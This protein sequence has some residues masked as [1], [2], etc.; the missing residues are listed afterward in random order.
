MSPVDMEC[1]MEKEDFWSKMDEVVEK[2]PKEERVV[3]GANFNGHVGEGNRVDSYS[4][5]ERNVEEQM[6]VD[7][8]KS[9]KLQW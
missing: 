2:V 8:A 5:M 4:V 9:M 1:E 7:F 6:V 3:V